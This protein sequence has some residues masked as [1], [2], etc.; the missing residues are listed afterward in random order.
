MI[1]FDEADIAE[2]IG[3]GGLSRGFKVHSRGQVIDADFNTEGTVITG[4]VRGGESKPYR[5]MITLRRNESGVTIH[6][7][8]SCPVGVNCK[9]VAAVLIEARRIA[10]ARKNAP[11]INPLAA[12]GENGAQRAQLSPDM[13]TWLNGVEAAARAGGGGGYSAEIKQR[14]I[15]V[16]EVRPE[17]NGGRPG[18]FISPMTAT[19]L[20]G[21]GLGASPRPYNPGNIHNYPPAKY[22][23][24]EDLEILREVAWLAR[25]N[26]N[27]SAQRICLP[28]DAAGAR[29]LCK[30]MAT[31]RCRFGDVQ[32]PVLQEGPQ[33]KASP[34]WSLQ[35]NGRQRLLF[36]AEEGGDERSPFGAVVPVA[37]PYYVDAEAGLC[38]PVACDLPD[39]V[40]VRMA[41]APEV[42]PAEAA[43]FAGAFDLRLGAI[44]LSGR[45][46]L[47]ATPAKTEMRRV[48]PVPRLHLMLA[49]A[50]IKPHFVWYH[51]EERHQGQLKLPLARLSFAYDGEIVPIESPDETIQRFAAGELVLMPRDRKAELAA[52]KRLEKFNLRQFKDIP[53]DVP[54]GR[55]QDLFISPP[56]R[57]SAY[58]FL[59]TFEDE[60]R[61]LE[62]SAESIPELAAEGWQIEYSDDYPY[63][64]ADGETA[65]W[66]DTG[67]G[68]GIDWFSFEL[69]IEFEGHRVNLIPT[70]TGLLAGL[71]KEMAWL[72]L[73]PAPED[74]KT[75]IE[76]CNIINLYHP[77]P[78][79]R[80]LP[81]PGERLAPLLKAL[82]QLIGPRS[83]RLIE[84]KVRLHRAEAANLAAFSDRAGTDVAWAASAERLAELGRNLRHGRGPKPVSP[85]AS[86]KADLRPYQLDGLAW[87]DFLREMGFGGVLADDMGLGKTVQALA[88]LALEKAE[89]R[90]DKP[91]LIVSPTSV[92]PNW[93]AEA[94]R[95]APELSVLALRGS[96]RKQDFG[97][98]GSHDLILTTYPLLMRDFG[99]LLEHEFHAAILDEAQAIKNPRAAISDI[100]HRINA[101]HRLALTGT[102]LENNLGE[103]WSLFQY[104][105]PG[106]LGDETSFRRI[107]RTPIEKHGDKAAQAYLSQRLKPF[108]LRRTK[109]EVAQDLPPKTEIIE[110][111]RLEGPQRDLY[112][113]VRSLMHKK[114][115]DEIAK[116][117]L[118]KSHI[119]FL[120]ALLKL[121]QICCDPRLLKMP[122]AHRVKRSAK[123]ER[124][125]EMLPEMVSEGHRILLFS[126]FTSMLALIEA[127]L[128]KAKIPFVTLT[129]DTKDRTGP[130][131]AFQS[132]KVPLFLL[133]LKAGGTGLNLTAADT[134]IHYDPWW[135][136][137][138]E[139]QA[140]D[141]AHR[142]GQDKPVFVY[143]LMVEEGIEAAIEMLKARKAA[144]A[145]ALFAGVAKSG[146]D[147]TEADIS[148]LFAPL[149]RDCF[150]EA[151]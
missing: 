52:A 141:R 24:P 140:T 58:E 80:L 82:M 108:M 131:K 114:V 59:A 84:G 14:L 17:I 62:F 68:S 76:H 11:E 104:L 35:P 47:P 89:G 126:Q 103:V 135:N 72:A 70:L 50:R 73:S 1:A 16:L 25:F 5:Q 146:L 23:L 138:V 75:F 64:I 22:L 110:H 118:A 99:V 105:S 13:L 136:P 87:L 60:S 150:R 113:T 51:R 142:I 96:E 97:K 69:G 112:E 9:H 139:N 27:S 18:G 49:E 101:R 77:L 91:A 63:R 93:Q 149:D 121:R 12:P 19:L 20:K 133:S 109:Q 98:I 81:L 46:P 55:P 74:E 129:G 32:G 28:S 120:D 117:G 83:D 132:G 31:G 148:A 37:P 65:W 78:D 39:M 36:E 119:V 106:L 6:G 102:P 26:S 124:L 85:P 57:P 143:K 48:K 94:G 107:F 123:L 21:G 54:S 147:L 122:Q 67:E 2:A 125:M 45:M 100:A 30:I 130:V 53:L 3:A 40:A 88:F 86:F 8:C 128:D 33:R 7:T 115:R 43:A 92:L 56:G 111:V 137:A 4:R 10:R 41:L 134:V 29:L 66:A 34:R 79:G 71:P 42:A 15:Y 38:G 95:F 90:L 127:E 61:F 145:D 44:G 144:L 151:A 116:K